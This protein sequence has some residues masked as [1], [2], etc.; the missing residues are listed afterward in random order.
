[1]NSFFESNILDLLAELV[2]GA[3]YLFDEKGTIVFRAGPEATSLTELEKRI[4]AIVKRCLLDKNR[5]TVTLVRE[6]DFSCALFAINNGILVLQN[7][8]MLDNRRRFRQIIEEALPYIAQVAGGDVVLFNSKGIREK[9]L[10]PDGRQNLD[11]VGLSTE[12]CYTTMLE[13]RPSIGPSELSPGSS[14]VRIP[15]TS[16]YGLAFNNRFATQQ[17]QRLINNARQY[18]YARYHFE[19]IVGNSAA[20]IK[21]KQLAY[22]AAKSNTTILLSG[23]TGTGKEVFAQAIH[24][25]SQR[26]Q[27]PFIAVNCGAV[28][29]ELVE[30]TLFGYAGG[31]FTG[32]KGSGQ[33]GCFEQANGGTIFLDEISEMPL[34][35]QVKLLRV[36]QEREISRIGENIPRPVDVRIIASTNRPLKPMVDDG[37]FRA[38]LYFRLKVLEIS[39]PPLRERSEDI[40]GLISLFI[41]R[42]SSLFGKPVYD[43]TPEAIQALVSYRWPGNVRE[44]Q[45]CFEYIFNILE[46][47]SHSITLEHLPAGIV[48]K[49]ERNDKA[50]SLYNELMQQVELD[51]VSRMMQQCQGNKTEAARRL[52]IN[53]TTLWRILKKYNLYTD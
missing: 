14:A 15:L 32:A 12:L 26:T 43:I 46:T 39:I 1:M 47:N 4:D 17:H 3:V 48:A 51:I 2:Q 28:P 8:Q 42:F 40:L 7:Y 18:N 35:A 22:G 27:L 38:D 20:M 21:A 31:S 29:P 25:H 6:P 24:N 11:A 13:S 45:N 36:L 5:Q 49:N 37:T 52:G 33:V 9:A 10:H 30:S 50:G 44:L 16:E 41:K 23:E 53:R 34:L 19:D